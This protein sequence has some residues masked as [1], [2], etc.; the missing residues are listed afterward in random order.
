MYYPALGISAQAQ[1]KLLSVKK[2]SVRPVVPGSPAAEA[3]PAFEPGD[4]IVGMTDPANPQGPPTV[5]PPDPR[6][7]ASGPDVNEYYRRLSLLSD[8]PITFQVVRAKGGETVPIAVA[9][10][11]RTDLGVRMRMGRVAA[12]R[13][14]GAAAEARVIASTEDEPNKGDRIKSV[15]L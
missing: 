7:P 15:R 12:L 2:R 4:R 13:A 9:P 3:N 14:G 8:K 10:T 6:D 5:L 1:L 11:P